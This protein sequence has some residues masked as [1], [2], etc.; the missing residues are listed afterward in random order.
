MGENEA[1]LSINV[2][3][4]RIATKW[5]WDMGPQDHDTVGRMEETKDFLTNP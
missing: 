3:K 4:A 2:K 5:T 1:P